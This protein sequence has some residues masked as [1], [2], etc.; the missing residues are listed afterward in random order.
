MVYLLVAISVC[1]LITSVDR[2]KGLCCVFVKHSDRM[3]LDTST[4]HCAVYTALQPNEE[5]HTREK[6]RRKE[7]EV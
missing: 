6:E 3:T 5:F 1:S 4:P 7:E 2:A